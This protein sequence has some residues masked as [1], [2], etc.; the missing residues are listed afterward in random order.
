[1]LLKIKK[2]SN[3]ILT[4]LNI[5][6]LLHFFPGSKANDQNQFSS[7]QLSRND[8]SI[9]AASNIHK[10][11][12]DPKSFREIDQFHIGLHFNIEANGVITGISIVCMMEIK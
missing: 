11:C 12:S 10:I 1:M 2:V 5:R 4:A 6:I 9:Q 8:E 7:C 3:P